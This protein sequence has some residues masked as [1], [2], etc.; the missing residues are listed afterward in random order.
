MKPI[1]IQ[2]FTKS[3][4]DRAERLLQEAGLKSDD[5]EIK[6]TDF[7]QTRFTFKLYPGL[8][9]VSAI[10]ARMAQKEARR[11]PRYFLRVLEEM[12]AIEKKILGDSTS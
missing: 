8:I 5:T 11:S 2:G 1:L 9:D 7:L 4:R 12:L 3:Q 10:Y 6:A